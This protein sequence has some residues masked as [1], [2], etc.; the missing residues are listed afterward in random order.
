MRQAN[1][2]I[3]Q[4]QDILGVLARCEVCRVA[5]GTGGAPYIVP[6]SFGHS[7]ENGALTLYF[8]GAREGRKIALIGPGCAAG[9]EADCSVELI[10]RDEP[11][12]YS[13]NYES[14]VGSGFIEPIDDPEE[15][16]LGLDCIMR[17]YGAVGEDYAYN[18][19]SLALTAVLRLTASEFTGKRLM[20]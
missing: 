18:E 1:R 4:I 14:I 12:K 7:Y 11:C 5:L 16:R 10:R 20:K 17:H 19:K 13:M 6:M 3:T 9:F 8:H 15:R 2:E